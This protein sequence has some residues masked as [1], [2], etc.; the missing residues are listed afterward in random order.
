MYLSLLVKEL[1]EPVEE[2]SVYSRE[3]KGEEVEQ[4]RSY[5]EGALTTRKTHQQIEDLHGRIVDGYDRVRKERERSEGVMLTGMLK[6]KAHRLLNLTSLDVGLLQGH[7]YFENSLRQYEIGQ[8][9]EQ[10]L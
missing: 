5:F 6:K 7:S 8:T 9:K 3:V 2:E 1:M 10:T 4:K